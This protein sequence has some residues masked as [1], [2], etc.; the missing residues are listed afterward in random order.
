M[1]RIV[2]A[3]L[4]ALA[5]TAGSARA[6]AGTTLENLQAAFNGESN[7]SARYKAFA[8][9]A[10]AEG[11]KA[12]GQLFRAAS[13][14]EAVHAANHAVV[15]KALGG[16]PKADVKAP[17]VKSTAENLKAAIAGESYERDSMYPEF[18]DRAKKDGKADAVRTL[19]LART[20]EI[21]HAKLYQASLDALEG[22]KVAGTIYVCPVCGYTT[23]TLPERCPATGTAKEKF[24]KID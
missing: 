18:L 20:A 7:A 11:Y 1:T 2:L 19:T 23:R 10:D 21:E 16:T 6:A 13:R 17:E 4:V 15:I 24:E 9:K 8:A 12:V 22:Q 3:A 14:S 5:G